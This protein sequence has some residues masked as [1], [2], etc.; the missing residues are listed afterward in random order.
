[1][2]KLSETT[3]LDII[4][5]IYVIG[6][7]VGFI[8]AAIL[9]DLESGFVGF[10]YLT[11]IYFLR[12]GSDVARVLLLIASWGTFIVG[13]LLTVVSFYDRD[14]FTGWGLFC[15]IF[16]V[17]SVWLLQFSKTFRHELESRRLL[18]K[19]DQT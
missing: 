10:I 16:G 8:S 18:N 5:I 3:K 17:T 13:I 9:K 11:L 12:R 15:L 14:I 4:S 6:A 2:K 7:I 1:M 19:K